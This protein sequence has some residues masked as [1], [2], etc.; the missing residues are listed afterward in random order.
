MIRKAVFK[1]VLLMLRIALP[2]RTASEMVAIVR[3][4]PD[5]V[6]AAVGELVLRVSQ[7]AIAARGRFTLALSGGSLPKVRASWIS[8]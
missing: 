3:P 2:R 8:R 6:G 7:E 1:L 4:T 5:D